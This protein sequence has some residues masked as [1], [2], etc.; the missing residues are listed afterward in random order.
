MLG[1]PQLSQT[2]CMNHAWGPVEAPCTRCRDICPADAIQMQGPLPLIDNVSCTSCTAC[3]AVC[4]TSA[5]AHD[6]VQTDALIWQARAHVLQGKQTLRA[7]CSAVSDP[8]ADLGIPCHAGWTPLLLACLAGEGVHMLELDGL[9]QCDDCPVR[10]GAQIMAETERDYATLNKSLGGRMVLSR[11]VTR[12]ATKRQDERQPEPERRAFFRKLIPSLAQ[13]AAMTVAQISDVMR[14]QDDPGEAQSAPELP[15]V[16]QAFA[17]LLPRLQP[18]FTPLPRLASIPIGSIQADDRCNA[19]GQCVGQ[20][21]TK[22]LELKAFGTNHILEFRPDACIGCDHCADIC[23]EHAIV[24]LP[25]L[26]LPAIAA[27]RSRPLVMVSADKA[28]NQHAVS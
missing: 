10:H 21:P 25:S 4:P 3:V 26:S 5:I 6:Q 18:T 23:P 2:E 20:C 27:R 15:A 13:G 17:R 12:Q 14:Q 9:T 19:C 16:L 24:P 11:E 1:K 7:A 28:G 22:A 8:S